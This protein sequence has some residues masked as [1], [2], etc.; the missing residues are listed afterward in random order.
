MTT[1]ATNLPD[2]L[3]SLPPERAEALSRL[4][5]IAAE[6]LL[7]GFEETV[8]YV[9]IN[10]VVPLSRFPAGY[11]CTPGE[12]LPFVTLASQAKH[13]ALYHMGLY[14]DPELLAWFQKAWADAGAGRLDTGKSCIRFANPAKIPYPVIAELLAKV[15]VDTY[16]AGYEASRAGR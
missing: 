5:E 6:A 2:Y 12:P 7:P 4:R 1:T 9:G 3:A 13:I 16:V 14:A 10:Y 11:H 15:D 8:G